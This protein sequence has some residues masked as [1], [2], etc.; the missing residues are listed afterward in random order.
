MDHQFNIFNNNN[1][2]RQLFETEH[3]LATRFY[4]YVAIQIAERSRI[5]LAKLMTSKFDFSHSHF[6]PP[7]PNDDF[8]IEPT[9]SLI[10]SR[11]RSHSNPDDAPNELDKEFMALFQFPT[12]QLLIKSYPCKLR[13]VSG[14]LYVS[15]DF[16]CFYGKVFGHTTKKILPIPQLTITTKKGKKKLLVN[17]PPHKKKKFVFPSPEMKE[18]A[19]TLI[20]SFQKKSENKAHQL[21][22]SYSFKV[23]QKKKLAMGKGD[24]EL[25][26][27]GTH[28]ISYPPG[29]T[30][31]TE[32]IRPIGM[33]QIVKGSCEIKKR[34]G[35]TVTTIA[36]GTGG[37]IGEMSFL[38]ESYVASSSVITETDVELYTLDYVF[39]MNLLNKNKS[40][41]PRFYKYIA[42]VI[43]HRLQSLTKNK[44]KAS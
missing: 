40:L 14:L 2:H 43:H 13:K 42:T 36:H 11:T 4:K 16:V 8:H 18:D 39:V 34:N 9:Q 25:L 35:E 7:P 22:R 12:P 19:L 26:L 1:V 41:A 30:I 21:H 10:K 17:I 3:D 37:I 5:F 15:K 23:K 27:Q 44:G 20:F 38:D 33:F 28:C 6:K 29:V 24:W 32:G 31:V